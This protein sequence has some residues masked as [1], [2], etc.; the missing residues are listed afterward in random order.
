MVDLL[1]LMRERRS[2]RGPYDQQRRIEKEE[3]E[4]I[5]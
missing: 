2:Q 3:L 4:R 1:T 5:R